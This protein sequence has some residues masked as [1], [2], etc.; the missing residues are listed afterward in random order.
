MFNYCDIR[1][2]LKCKKAPEEGK[3]YLRDL[4]VIKLLLFIILF[5]LLAVLFMVMVCNVLLHEKNN[6]HE[7]RNLFWMNRRFFFFRVFFFDEKF[8]FF[9]SISFAQHAIS[10]TSCFQLVNYIRRWLV[11]SRESHLETAFFYLH[12]YIH[13]RAYFVFITRLN[14][15]QLGI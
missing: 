8:L 5:L 11:T 14:N 15:E 10:F 6:K 12:M 3:N 9:L 1:P 2:K 13:N 7:S 4:N